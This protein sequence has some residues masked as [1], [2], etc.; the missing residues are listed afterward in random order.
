M[1]DFLACSEEIQKFVNSFLHEFESDSDYIVA[2][3]SGSTGSP[4]D[5]KLLKSDMLASATAT[6]NFFNIGRNSII[7]SPLS[8]RFI[9]GKMMIVRGVQA[10]CRVIFT[11]PS[12]HFWNSREVTDYIHT[13]EIDLLPIVPSQLKEL[14]EHPKD[15]SQ[16][17]SSIRN[18][19]V[20]GA[21]VDTHDEDQLKPYHSKLFATY[22]MTETCSH[23]ALRRFGQDFYNAMPGVSFKT[24]QRDCLIVNAPNFSFRSLQTNDIVDLIS[25]VSF[26]WLGRFDNVIN[27]GGIKIFPEIIEKALSHLLQHPFYI[28]GEPHNKWGEAVCLVTV[29]PPSVSD[30]EI[31]GL[32]RCALKPHEIP[33]SILRVKEIPLT[34]NGKIRRI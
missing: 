19:I 8:P 32:C 2:H 17:I 7:L 25:P 33:R 1:I 22:G 3:T 24:D 16:K 23:V 30:D 15:I 12:N 34:S 29:A 28:K 6:N 27:S 20:G 31:I 14:T 9:A 11:T 13:H 5:I 4:K 10:D 21:S 18:I 26:R